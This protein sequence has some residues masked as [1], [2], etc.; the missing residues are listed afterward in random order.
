MT[1]QGKESL[2]VRDIDRAKSKGDIG[3]D[4]TGDSECNMAQ[5]ATIS[6]QDGHFHHR[7]SP[8]NAFSIA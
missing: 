8:W 5:M 1:I 6:G 2:I 3:L 4:L 7:G